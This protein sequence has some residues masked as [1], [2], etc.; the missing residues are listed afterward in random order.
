MTDAKFDVFLSHNSQD[1]PSVRELMQH[2]LGYQ[3]LSGDP[4]QVWFD[5][6]E[7]QPGLPWQEPRA[8]VVFQAIKK[9]PPVIR[10]K[11]LRFSAKLKQVELL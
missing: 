2:L 6:D 3:N 11:D 5:E 9:P 7:L 8:P 1:K 4:I 10:P